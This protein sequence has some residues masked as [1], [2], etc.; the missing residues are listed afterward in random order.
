VVRVLAVAVF[1]ILV[2]ASEPLLPTPV[3]SGRLPGG[4]PCGFVV[5]DTLHA[6]CLLSETPDRVIAYQF[7]PTGFAAKCSLP[8]LGAALTGAYSSRPAGFNLVGDVDDDG[9]DE[10]VVAVNCS[11]SKYKWLDGALVLTSQ[12]SL[13]LDSHQLWATDGCVGDVDNDGRVELL[14]AGTPSW[15]PIPGDDATNPVTLFVCRWD[16]DSLIHLWNDA[17]NLKLELPSHD[18]PS[19]VMW[20]IADP[21]NTGANRLILLE[22]TG[23]DVHPAVYREL[24]W[25]EGGL[26]DDGVFLLRRSQLKRDRSE[27]DPSGWATNCDFGR[28]RGKTVI[29]ADIMHERCV[30]QGEYFVF[31]GD[32]LAQHRLLWSDKDHNWSS[33]STGIL[34]NLDGKGIGA[35]RIMYPRRGGPRYEFYRL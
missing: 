25:R 27:G 23:D 34:V 9:A 10:F 26:R 3:Y 1:P 7:G 35:L 13:S 24:A 6:P 28:V 29:L 8:K 21:R 11:L 17:G 30:W 22:G 16:E 33:P 32:S 5:L 2:L 20:A 4:T 14:I 18:L 19:E 15:P 12:A 31:D